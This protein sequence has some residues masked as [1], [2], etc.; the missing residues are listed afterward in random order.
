MGGEEGYGAGMTRSEVV[1]GWSALVGGTQN[2]TVPIKKK[3]TVVPIVNVEVFVPGAGGPGIQPHL[4]SVP[5]V[6]NTGWR[7]YGNQRG[8]RRLVDAFRK[9]RIPATAVV[10]SEAAAIPDV[11]SILRETLVY[12][13]DNE[14]CSFCWEMGAHGINNS[15]GM[16]HMN[17]Q[18]EEETFRKCLD[19]L[20]SSLGVRPTTWLTPQFSITERTPEIA[21]GAGIQTLLDFVD[22]DVPYYLEHHTAT[23]TTT[24]EK[25]KKK[26]LLCVPYGM[27]TNDF[28]LVLTKNHTPRQYAE[29]ME[30]HILQL[31]QEE[32]ETVV[33]LGMHT[34]VAGTPSRVRALT[35]LFQRLKNTEGV[36]FATIAQ[37]QQSTM[38]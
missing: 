21:T 10:N 23:T 35:E 1:P 6:A 26:K 20:E 33:C 5:E 14:G 13:D 28:S 30:D 16:S 11:A 37:I 17:R 38:S 25:K 15:T 2:N 31:L 36:Q 34:F 29:A 9:L 4:Q 32:E 7:K 12:N 18:E 8:L 3:V 22:D 24:T 19:D 27:E